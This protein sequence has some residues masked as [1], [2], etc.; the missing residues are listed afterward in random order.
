GEACGIRMLGLPT[1]R[2]L[3]VQEPQQAGFVLGL[4]VGSSVI[5][6]H[7]YDRAARVCGSSAQKENWKSFSQLYKLA[8]LKSC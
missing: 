2:E 8:R 5:R 4:D 6:C 1:D 7:V 3:R